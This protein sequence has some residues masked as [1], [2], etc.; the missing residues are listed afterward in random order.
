MADTKK[1]V[2]HKIRTGIVHTSILLNPHVKHEK[3]ALRIDRCYCCSTP[4]PTHTYFQ[5]LSR[6]DQVGKT[7]E[8]GYNIGIAPFPSETGSSVRKKIDQKRG[9]VVRGQ[10][11]H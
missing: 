5:V 9:V 3:R 10:L 11:A 8:H 1:F 7:K 6:L 4:S 2:A